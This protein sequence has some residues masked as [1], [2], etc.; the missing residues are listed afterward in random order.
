MATNV[1]GSNAS[2][3]YVAIYLS[4]DSVIING[5]IYLGRRYV[6][7]LAAGVSNAAASVVGIPTIVGYDD[8]GYG[9]GLAPG[10]YYIEALATQPTLSSSPRRTMPW[11]GTRSR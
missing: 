5:N 2:S 1:V 3:Y 8:E 9:I 10:T 6:G 4:A 11:R 7:G